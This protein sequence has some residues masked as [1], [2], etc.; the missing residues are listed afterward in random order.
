MKQ[1]SKTCTQR[2]VRGARLDPR[3]ACAAIA[4]IGLLVGC[5]G[6]VETTEAADAATDI[7]VSGNRDY[8]QV[9]QRVR[10]HQG[11]TDNIYMMA[12]ALDTFRAEVGR[13]PKDLIELLET[14]FVD[15]MP[16]APAG[17]YY[18]YNSTNGMISVKKIPGSSRARMPDLP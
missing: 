12:E 14:G 7:T 18:G 4:A 3:C 17:T 11:D 2:R 10:E 5:S 6:S 15:Q 16:E 9:L 8:D 1:P 13:S